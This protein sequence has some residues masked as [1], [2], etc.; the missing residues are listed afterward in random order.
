MGILGCLAGWRAARLASCCSS[1]LQIEV[2]NNGKRDIPSLKKVYICLSS[3]D[4]TRTNISY[5]GALSDNERWQKILARPLGSSP[6]SLIRR[7][8]KFAWVLK[9]TMTC[10]LPLDIYA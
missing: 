8:F 6:C 1:G 3:C 9:N 10:G 4:D 7:E 5:S 2:I